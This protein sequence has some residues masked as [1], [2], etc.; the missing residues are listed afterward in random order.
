MSNLSLYHPLLIA[1]CLPPA[2]Q[3]QQPQQQD[4]LFESERRVARGTHSREH[5]S[6]RHAIFSGQHSKRQAAASSSK[7]QASSSMRTMD[8]TFCGRPFKLLSAILIALSVSSPNSDSTTTSM[9]LA[10]V[11]PGACCLTMPYSCD[12]T[13]DVAFLSEVS[14]A[15]GDIST[16]SVFARR[17][18]ARSV[19]DSLTMLLQDARTSQAMGSTVSTNT[20]A[21]AIAWEHEETGLQPPGTCNMTTDCEIAA[22]PQPE[23]TLPSIDADCRWQALTWGSLDG[24]I[25]EAISALARG[26][27]ATPAEIESTAALFNDVIA[28]IQLIS[29]DL[30]SVSV[31]K[32]G[33][34]ALQV[35]HGAAGPVSMSLLS[36]SCTLITYAWHG[37][38]YTALSPPVSA[39]ACSSHYL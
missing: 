15:L 22:P 14:L 1:G 35:A 2:T 33:M 17:Y 13:E 36:A 7:Q 11:M 6:F 16:S 8:S 30:E 24:T 34:R 19:G 25:R 10:A 26:V 29:E 12:T 3:Q 28:E 38:Q 37:F 27:D 32:L 18:N 31:A 21:L 5:R 20:T 23:C 9:E 4:R 39:C